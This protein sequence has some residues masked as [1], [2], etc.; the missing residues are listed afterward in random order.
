MC[1][2]IPLVIVAIVAIATGARGQVDAAHPIA[3]S[4]KGLQVQTVDD[5]LAL[6]VG[7]AALN[8]NLGQLFPADAKGAIE[9]RDG[10][11]VFRFSR[12]YLESL[13]A[14]IL[15]LSQHGV[16]VTLI[17]IAVATGDSANDALLLHPQYDKAAPN[18]IGAFNVVTA[19]GRRWL[20]AAVGCLAQRWSG[21]EPMHGRVS[22]WIVGN[23]VNSHWWWFNL[24]HRTPAEVV[25]AYEAAVRIV[26]AAV[27]RACTHARVY[28]SLEHHW[29]IRYAAGDAS[30][31]LPGRQLL[32]EFAALARARGDFD[33]HVAF[34]PYPENLFDCRFWNDR[35]APDRDDADRIT[36]R[37]L[38]VLARFLATDAL[39][40]RGQTR[41]VILS[42]QGFHCRNDADGE[43]DQ[44]AAFAA[45]WMAVQAEPGIDALI[46]HRHVDH[47]QEGGLQLGLWSRRPDSVCT[48][49]KQRRIYSVFR[50]CTGKDAANALAF[51]LPVLGIES[52]AALPARL[53]HAPAVK[54]PVVR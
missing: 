4:K 37:N 22:N 38:P 47:S 16:V 32:G 21:A 46:L 51:A 53:G 50:D 20:A 7:H 39:R 15:P 8:C 23:E 34:H 44:A 11:E 48:P 52:W 33:W 26:H 18:H 28:V 24:G 13:D 35:S 43:R 30:Q 3:A 17:L 49:D 41:R 54:P 1:R 36:F 9:W 5:A 2:G 27:R 6:G 42:E 10:G 14:Q 40:C 31:C 45:A 12:P 19:E 29:N 25:D